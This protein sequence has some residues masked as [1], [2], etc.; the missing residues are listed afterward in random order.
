MPD[1]LV[2]QIAPAAA[3]GANVVVQR[4]VHA[5]DPDENVLGMVGGWEVKLDGL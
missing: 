1:G 3:V 2:G 4:R 5:H